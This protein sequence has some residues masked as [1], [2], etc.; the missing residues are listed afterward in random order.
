MGDTNLVEAI[1]DDFY[2]TLYY[3]ADTDG[4]SSCVVE[5]A[6]A[7][8]PDSDQAVRDLLGAVSWP[9]WSWSKDGGCTSFELPVG[10]SIYI[11]SGGNDPN[12][13]TMGS[14]AITV[15]LNSTPTSGADSSK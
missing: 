10:I 2:L 11:D 14:S 8:G 1:R 13:E 3:D 6:S 4:F 15:S 7:L 9:D 5:H 12:C